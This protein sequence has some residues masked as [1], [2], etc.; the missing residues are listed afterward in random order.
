MSV[1][2]P[3][4]NDF[5]PYI[6]KTQRLRPHLD[7]DRRR[8]SRD[9][10]YVHAVREDPTRGPAVRRERSMASTSRTT[11]VR[12]WQSLLLNMPDV[13]VADL[14]VEA[15]ELVIATHGRSFWVLDN[16]APLRQANAQMRLAAAVHLFAPPAAI[17]QA[18]GISITWRL[19]SAPQRATLEILDSAGAVMRHHGISTRRVN[20]AALHAR[21]VA[22]VGAVV[23]RCVHADEAGPQPVRVGSA[24]VTAIIV[25]SRA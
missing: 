22:D 8:H 21:P 16:I 1:R 20:A 2:K 7:E 14:I 25:A 15:N 10:D 19:K 6:W 11:M 24:H 13:P 17:A 3:L 9:D 5:S 23:V 12:H 4:L 18:A